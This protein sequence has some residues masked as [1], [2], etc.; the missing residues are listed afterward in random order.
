MRFE[1]PWFLLLLPLL[2]LLWTVLVIFAA[3]RRRRKLTALLGSRAGDPEVVRLSG[4][5]RYWRYWL[6]FAGCAALVLGLAHPYWHT[7]KL[8]RTADASDVLVIG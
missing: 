5:V 2:L 7:E 3:H 4:A 1:H 6:L 8:P